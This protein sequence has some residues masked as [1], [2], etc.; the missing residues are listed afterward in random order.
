VG[1]H[2]TETANRS[3]GADFVMRTNRKSGSHAQGIGSR[4]VESGLRSVA[5]VLK[6][7]FP[8]DGVVRGL[9]N[10]SFAAL[11]VDAIDP[12]GPCSRQRVEK[13]ICA[14]HRDMAT[15]GPLECAI[16]MG[17]W[18]TGCET[19]LRISGLVEANAGGAAVS[20]GARCLLR[21]VAPRG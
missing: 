9:A 2:A 20:G 14:L 15:E 10:R 17:F 5:S 4:R 16:S 11:A 1:A 21:T 19:V 13:A 8:A 3:T 7:C 18:S 12:A 6:S